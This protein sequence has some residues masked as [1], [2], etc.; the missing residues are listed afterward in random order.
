MSTAATSTPP[1]QPGE[2]DALLA[3]ISQ[4]INALT[5]WD[6]AAFQS[7]IERQA[8]ICD[9]IALKPGLGRPPASAAAVHRVQHLNRVYERLLQHSVHWT[10]TIHAILQASGNLHSRRPSVHFRG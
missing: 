6:V 1:A 2:L 5:A 7:A 10:R 4:A 8:E 3:A 9:R